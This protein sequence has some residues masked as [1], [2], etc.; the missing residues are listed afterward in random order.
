MS[1]DDVLGTC[2]ILSISELCDDR[3]GGRIGEEEEGDKCDPEPVPSSRKLSHHF[4]YT[5][6][7]ILMNRTF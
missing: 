3:D 7:A 6:L 4:P 5:V 1:V 2:G